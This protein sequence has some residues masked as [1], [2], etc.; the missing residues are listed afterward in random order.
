M[1]FR[2]FFI[3]LL[4]ICSHSIHSQQKLIELYQENE[5]EK[6]DKK[7]NKELES[8]AKGKEEIEDPRVKYVK[9]LLFNEKTY[10]IYNTDSA[11]KYILISEKVLSQVVD[12]KLKEDLQ[13]NQFDRNK[14]SKAMFDISENAY[15]AAFQKDT[16]E[17]YIRFLQNYSKGSQEVL[18]KAIISRNK[19]AFKKASEENS[20][21]SYQNFITKY[22]QANEIP[23]AIENRDKLAFDLAKNENS[24]K[25]YKDFI[26]S[27]PNAKQIN[28]A[29]ST[30]YDLDFIVTKELNTAS[31]YYKHISNYPKSSHYS[32]VKQ[33]SYECEFNEN[34]VIG[35]IDS[36]RKFVDRFGKE[37]PKKSI[38]LDSLFNFYEKQ[39]SFS[40]LE[41]CINNASSEQRN[42][43]LKR[44]HYIY[45]VDGEL[46]TLD[47]F[48][49]KYNDNFLKEIKQ[50]DYEIA[51]LGKQIK[52]SSGYSEV[53]FDQY[54]KYIKLAAP[55][56]RAFVALQRMIKSD[57]DSKN[58]SN[59]L[60]TANSY[61]S[62]FSSNKNFII[63]TEMLSKPSD[64]S[65]IIKEIDE[66][67]N[68][69]NGQHY[70]PK[71][72]ADEKTIYFCAK[73]REENLG[74]EDIFSSY[75][76]QNKLWSSPSI[77]TELSTSNGHEAPEHVSADNTTFYF[78]RN[79]TLN[80]GE[81]TANG[82]GSNTKELSKSINQG[83]WQADI[84]VS[85]DGS[86]M[87]FSSI[88]VDNF[89]YNQKSSN[90][91]IGNLS[92]YHGTSG[93]QSDIYVSLKDSYGN[94]GKAINLGSVINTI[95]CDRSAFLHPD[96]K[97]LYFSS[98]GHGG[99]G[100]LDVFVSKRL[101]DSCWNCWSEPVNLGKEINSTSSD[102]G[103]NISTSGDKAYF[104]RDSKIANLTLPK[105]LRPNFV[106]TVSGTVTDDN[107]EIV[108]CSIVWEDL[109]TGKVIGTSKSN[110]KDGTYYM[111]LPLGKNYGYY[112]E[113]EGYFPI[114]NNV[115]VKSANKAISIT[116]DILLV[117]LKQMVEKSTPVRLNNLFFNSGK[118]DLLP[119]SIPELKRVA[120][121]IKK[122]KM[123]VEISGHT[124]DIGETK[125][126]EEL[127]K[128]RANSVKTFLLSQGITEDSM[129]SIGYGESKP[130]MPNTTD[131]G[132]SKNRRVELR[133]IK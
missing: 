78:F 35:N 115:D 37:N 26:S 11:Y 45:T 23:S 21:G 87:L 127:S 31:A 46:S 17:E 104:S 69:I 76:L 101:A 49:G 79:G 114:S 33:L 90:Q 107:G 123:K 110:P 124:D 86:A 74:G 92:D 15:Q 83:S 122:E 66:I 89:N 77:I 30:I 22:P 20:I 64:N 96:M 91:M 40:N 14:I 42:L 95:H 105:H 72:S 70:S 121:I 75:R 129:I 112:I 126:N 24:I 47:K 25:S 6:A 113:K 71:L 128:A 59:A 54:D 38:V 68:S 100:S 111:V 55:K 7:V 108:A 120:E 56:D 60:K 3:V 94:W 65:I 52:L 81:F 43:L 67:N 18:N 109:E 97:T 9:A 58:Y 8:L 103:Y 53:L 32:E 118:S 36:Y 10:N 116:E 34:V 61:A 98:D 13:K 29:W 119:S 44:Y 39:L 2:Y 27:Y 12:V 73:D 80:Q 132:R 63:L 48:Y 51:G 131:A 4:T 1:I 16:E 50:K 82:I 125:M 133:F 5:F 88:F 41:Y 130:I 85:G 117:S 57:I 84:C 62:F 99:L 28:E 106:A 93:H 19:V 102:W